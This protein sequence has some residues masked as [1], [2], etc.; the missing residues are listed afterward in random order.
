L[1]KSQKASDIQAAPINLVMKLHQNLA[2]KQQNVGDLSHLRGLMW[3]FG[4]LERCECAM[5]SNGE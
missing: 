2:L 5:L 4:R 3:C 1:L